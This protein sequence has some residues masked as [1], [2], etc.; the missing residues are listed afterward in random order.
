M[1]IVSIDLPAAV[2]YTRNS[3]MTNGLKR[4]TPKKFVSYMKYNNIVI[5]SNILSKPLIESK[6]NKA[7]V[8]GVR[9]ESKRFIINRLSYIEYITYYRGQGCV[10]YEQADI[11]M[12]SS[13][14]PSLSCSL[15]CITSLYNSA[16]YYN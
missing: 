12:V 5:I 13:L 9:N 11:H 16:L 14:I 10:A 4:N 7:F 1:H 6:D 15:R 3:R 2:S 8:V